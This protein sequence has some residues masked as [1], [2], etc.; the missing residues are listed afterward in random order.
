M[1]KVERLLIC[2][3]INRGRYVLFLEVQ[4]VRGDEPLLAMRISAR[5]GYH[6]STNKKATNARIPG[7]LSRLRGILF[8]DGLPRVKA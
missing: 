6:P 2:G 8:V 1:I 5:R 3:K 4:E 7:D